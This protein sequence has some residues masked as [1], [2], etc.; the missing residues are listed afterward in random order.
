M[1]HIIPLHGDEHE[2][3]LLLLPWHVTGRLGPD[4]QSRVEAHLAACAECRAEVRSEEALKAE[5]DAM[6]LAVEAGWARLRRRIEAAP[7]VARRDRR[8]P[9]WVGWALAAQLLLFVFLGFQ[10]AP[11]LRPAE[12]RTLSAAPAPVARIIVTFRPDTREEDL[13]T[14][15]NSISARLVGGPTATNAY[16]LAAPAAERANAL[17]KLRA[18]PSVVVAEAL[19]A[20]GTR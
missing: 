5:V 20:N 18:Q 13:R 10:V 17:A 2:E 7:V 11:N 14:A 9:A 15:L 16:V 1:A 4:E 12:Y 8:P 3:V 6:P 19:D